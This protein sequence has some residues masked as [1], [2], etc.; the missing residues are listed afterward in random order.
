LEPVALF[1]GFYDVPLLLT[2]IKNTFFR[3]TLCETSR[4]VLWLLRHKHLFEQ[5][6]MNECLNETADH[7]GT[8]TEKLEAWEENK[9][10][11]LTNANLRRH[12]KVRLQAN[13]FK[14]RQAA[15]SIRARGE[16]RQRRPWTRYSHGAMLMRH[17][18][19]GRHIRR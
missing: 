11:K 19:S 3:G 15:K 7:F 13:K 16:I 14:L 6:F 1:A 8:A 12:L 5:K 17:L 2:Y 4:A 9:N 18:A 10:T